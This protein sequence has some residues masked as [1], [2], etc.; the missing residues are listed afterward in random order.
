MSAFARHMQELIRFHAPDVLL[1]LE[2][3]VTGDAADHVCASLKFLKIHRIDENGFKGGI[4]LLWNPNKVMIDVVHETDE[5]IRAVIQV[6]PSMHAWFLTGIYASPTRFKRLSLWSE[7]SE[8]ASTI[9]CLG[10][11]FMI[12]MK[13]LFSRKREVVNLSILLQLFLSL[14]A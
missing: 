13:S 5:A 10:W 9:I 3:K 8:L 1:L 6:I 12:L 4:W 7:L 14:F 11:L 2:T